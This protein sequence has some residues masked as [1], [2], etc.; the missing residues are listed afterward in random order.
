MQYSESSV[1]RQRVDGEA[2]GPAMFSELN[3]LRVPG[4]PTRRL[5]VGIFPGAGGAICTTPS[6]PATSSRPDWR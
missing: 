2:S 6:T 3:A 5:T 1:D 4:E